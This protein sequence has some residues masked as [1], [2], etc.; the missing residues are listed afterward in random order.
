MMRRMRRTFVFVALLSSATVAAAAVE[1]QK[2]LV[3]SAFADPSLVAP[4]VRLEVERPNGS[5]YAVGLSGWTVDGEW[6]RRMSGTRALRFAAD[7]TPLNAHNSNL[8]YADGER[9]PE[10]EYEN[11]SYRARGGLRFTPTARTTTDVMAVALYEAVDGLA[12]QVEERWSSPYAGVDVTHTYSAV[13]SRE[14][15]IGAFNGLEVAARAEL[16]AGEESWSRVSLVV[17]GGRD[18]GRLHFR[19]SI[20][21]LHGNGLDVVNRFLIGGSWDALGG[22]AIYGSRYG[23]FRVNR[24]MILNAGSDFRL[25]RNWRVGLRSSYA[26]GDETTGGL[27]LNATK[28]W[29]TIGANFGVGTSEQSEVTFYGALIVPLYKK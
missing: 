6:M 20:A 17:R 1:E 24:A 9:A 8:I 22:T 14:P 11:A 19:Q 21:L 12:P 2:L 15:L 10:L 26:R 18:F 3:S 4:V 23:E 28:V 16:L 5:S 25:P 27:A 7:A 29:K 13:T